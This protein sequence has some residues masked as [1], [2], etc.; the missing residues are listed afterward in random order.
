[1]IES[2]GMQSAAVNGRSRAN[3]FR[4]ERLGLW[5]MPQVDRIPLYSIRQVEA[6]ETDS[7]HAGPSCTQ[8]NLLCWRVARTK[9]VVR[10]ADFGLP[11][12]AVHDGGDGGVLLPRRETTSRLLTR[13]LRP[14]RLETEPKTAPEAAEI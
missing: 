13:R 11:R 7:H 2:N 14:G 8:A 4:P 12:R 5:R 10:F 3:P 9:K 1:M 6:C